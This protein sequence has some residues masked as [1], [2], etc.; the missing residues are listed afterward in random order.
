MII[1]VGFD[2]VEIKRIERSLKTYKGRFARKYFTDSERQYCSSQKKPSQ[3]YAARFAAKEA[4][5]KAIGEPWP[6]DCGHIDVEVIL[7]DNG[8]P[9]LR[10]S[11]LLDEFLKKKGVKKTFISISHTK[12]NATAIVIFEG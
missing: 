6:D 11:D 2:I 5:F 1:S 4:A 8:K 7:D 9:S 10:F 3:H 12:E